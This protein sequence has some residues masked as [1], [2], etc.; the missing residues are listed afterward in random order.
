MQLAPSALHSTAETLTGHLG[1][2][3]QVNELIIDGIISLNGPRDRQIGMR[4]LG[5]GSSIQLWATGGTEPADHEPIEGTIPLPSGRRWH[6]PVHIGALEADKDP[7]VVLYNAITDRLLPVFDAKPLYVGHRPW[8]LPAE[9]E[10]GAADDEATAPATSATDQRDPEAAPQALAEVAEPTRHLEAVPAPTGRPTPETAS[11]PQAP[12]EQSAAEPHPA[13]E[14]K[15][16][17]KR[18]RRSKAATP[19]VDGD[20]NP[21]TTQKRTAATPA[22]AKAAT[23]ATEGKPKPRPARKRTPAK[24]ATS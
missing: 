21:S 24:P 1:D 17:A 10:A 18:T 7:G 15:P 22:T 14:P 20:A 3:W 2:N 12:T 13:P 9:L 16:A 8:N 4:L 11:V 19:A 6:T 23:P 5:D